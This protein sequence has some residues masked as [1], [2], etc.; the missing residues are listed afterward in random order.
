MRLKS[1]LI[2][3]VAEKMLSHE[4]LEAKRDKFERARVKSGTPHLVEFFHDP[5]DP[6][7]QLLE[8]ALQ[9]FQTR[10][11]VELIKHLV[12]PPEADAAP[13]REKLRE[14]AVLDADRLARRAGIDFTYETRLPAQNTSQADARLCLL[15]TSPSPRD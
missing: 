14:Y 5:S 15:Y 10:Y 2:S 4:T 8:R 6:Y 12:G 11:D 7:S 9:D 3:R 13:E 1:H